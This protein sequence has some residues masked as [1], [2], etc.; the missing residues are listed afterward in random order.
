MSKNYNLDYYPSE[1]V[2]NPPPHVK[3]EV[4]EIIK[5]IGVDFSEKIVDFG[6]GTGRLA[7]P[8]LR[9][10]YQVLA[11]DNNKESLKELIKSA[12]I[13]NKENN[14]KTIN[15]LPAK[16]KFNLIVGTDILHHLNLDIWLPILYKHLNSGGRIIFSEPNSWYLL[17]WLFIFLFLDFQEEK[18]IG[19][20][21]YFGL[22][23]RLEKVGFKNIKISGFGLLFPLKIFSFR[24]I[25]SAEK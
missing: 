5:K 17:W 25:I 15:K 3:R 7:I 8:L 12:K 13:I 10:N 21:S 16:D 1:K 6:A 18:G 23:R 9:N 11:V 20:I 24:L 22:R 14:L 2:L 19:Q 4:S